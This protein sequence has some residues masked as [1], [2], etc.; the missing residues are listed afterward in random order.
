MKIVVIG[1]RGLIGSKVATK[2][3]AQGHDVLAA[4]RRSGVDSLTGEGLADAFAGADVVV[5]VADS[6]LFD[7]EPVMHFFTTATTNLSLPNRKRESNTM[8][9]CP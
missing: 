2:L 1:G 7:D 3:S 4:S 6:P 9:R 8:S 5:D